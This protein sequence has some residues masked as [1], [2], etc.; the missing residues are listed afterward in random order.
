MNQKF[1]NFCLELGKKA[2][3]HDWKE[4]ELIFIEILN[5]IE[6]LRQIETLCRFAREIFKNSELRVDEILCKQLRMLCTNS[7][8]GLGITAQNSLA[9]IMT[10]LPDGSDS[11]SWI[12]DILDLQRNVSQQGLEDVPATS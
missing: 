10:L 6:D 11:Y 9:K 7:G 8:V 12:K 4:A 3:L 1:E 2:A 5:Q